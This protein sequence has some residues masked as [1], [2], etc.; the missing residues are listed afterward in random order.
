MILKLTCPNPIFMTVDMTLY[1]FDTDQ[2]R[3]FYEVSFSSDLEHF[4]IRKFF[5]RMWQKG[6]TTDCATY[7]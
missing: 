5:V 1:M 4:T 7:K 2:V 3:T 6:Y